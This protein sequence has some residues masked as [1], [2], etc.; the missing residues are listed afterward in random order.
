MSSLQIE[1]PATLRTRKAKTKREKKTRKQLATERKQRLE[2]QL[3]QSSEAGV[4]WGASAIGRIVNLR[5]P[6]VYHLFR[7]GW[8]GDAVRKFGPEPE[9]GEPDKRPLVGVVS[10]LRALIG[11]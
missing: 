1:T 5:G 2:C 10:K 9:E 6:Q 3:A 4:V 8:F 11:A 7:K